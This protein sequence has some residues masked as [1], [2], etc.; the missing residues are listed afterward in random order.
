MTVRQF[1]QQQQR[2]ITILLDLYRQG[3][4]EEELEA[5]EKAISF[6]ATLASKTVRQGRDRLAIAIAAESLS[7]YP[8]ILSPLLVN[9][10]LDDLAIASDSEAPDL[11]GAV[12]ALSVPIQTNSRLLVVSTRENCLADFRGGDLDSLTERL[13]ATVRTRWLNDLVGAYCGFV[14]MLPPKFFRYE[15]CDH[16][17]YTQVHGHDPEMILLPI[18]FLREKNNRF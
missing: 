15:H 11:L 4:S 8:A 14:I 17:T 6:V 10:V 2:Q 16:H 9:S 5:V 1:E 13:L 7:A 12:R 3:N 18:S